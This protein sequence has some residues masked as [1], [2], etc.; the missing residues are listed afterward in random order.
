M[1]QGQA[2]PAGLQASHAAGWIDNSGIEMEGWVHSSMEPA[3]VTPAQQQLQEACVLR[4]EC[5]AH[6]NLWEARQ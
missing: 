3:P 6:L 5:G 2:L 1:Y 4:A